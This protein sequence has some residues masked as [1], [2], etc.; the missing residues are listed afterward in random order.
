MLGG[1][2]LMYILEGISNSIAARAVMSAVDREDILGGSKSLD[3][4][5]TEFLDEVSQV[6]LASM[7]SPDTDMSEVGSLLILGYD[8]DGDHAC[9]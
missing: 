2:P 1:F 7:R 5:G 6:L 4:V 9:I 3:P 8:G